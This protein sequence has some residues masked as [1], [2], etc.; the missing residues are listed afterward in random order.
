MLAGF[1]S[2]SQGLIADGV[3]SLSD[4]FAD[5][6]VLLANR[7]SQKEAD[8]DHPYGHQRYENAAS[9]ALGVLLLSVGSGM[10]WA[11]GHKLLTPAVIVQ[12]KPLALWVALIA[13]LSK[14]LLFHYMLSAARRVA[15]SMLIANAWH[16][17]SDA[18]SSLVVALGIGG[19]LLGYHLLDP[20]AGLLVGLMVGKMGWG[21]A[22][23]A[24]NDL[25]D[26]AASEEQVAQLQ[27]CL[28]DTPGVMGIHGL[29][30]RKMG[31]LIIVDAHLEID[32]ELTVR[33][34]HDIAVEA[35][36]RVMAC[37]PVMDVTT[38]V[39]PAQ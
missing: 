32:G 13:L 23:D 27:Q 22:W 3:H 20:L 9:L 18:A 6:V 38:H 36:D 17:R 26:H 8:H 11:A 28:L 10:S 16:A 39:D 24:M 37:L 1:L 12:V 35:R 25:M 29:R 14:E 2:G 30:T 19:N 33:Q 7:H 15:S 4:L 34:G 21:F 5:F 31:D